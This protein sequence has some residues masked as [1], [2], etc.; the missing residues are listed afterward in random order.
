[1]LAACAFCLAPSL[2]AQADK[3]TQLLQNGAYQEAKPL[4]QKLVKQSPSNANYNYGYGVCCY[5]TGEADAALVYLKRSAD[6]KVIDAF[7]YLGK[8]YYDTYR[9]DEAV[10]SYEEYI[11]WL[12]KKKRDTSRAEE[13]LQRA[14]LAARMLK[15]VEQVTVVD[16]FVVDKED[17]L[18]AYKLSREA[19]T[20]TKSEAVTAGVDYVNERESK[21]IATV[22]LDNGRKGLTS[23]I[24][25]LNTWSEPE[26]ISSLS[27]DGNVNYPFLL[28]DGVTLYYAADGE[29]SM[30]G[31]DLFM[32]RYDSESNAYLRPDHVG[33]P[34]NSPANDYMMAIDES[35]QLGW[36]VSDRYQPEGKA[37]VYVFVPND[38]KEVYD[39]D[40][41]DEARLIAA[42]SLRSIRTTW[43]D[44]SVVD[45]AR[46]R[47]AEAQ[48]AS[49]ELATKKKR[50]FTFVVSDTKVCHTL[51][52]FTRE[53]ARRAYRQYAQKEQDLKQ[54]RQSLDA[55]RKQY[56]A[57]QKAVGA[58]I[59]DLE[60]R[61]EDM[62]A[63]LET[64]AGEVRAKELK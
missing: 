63:E 45:A 21:R 20:L 24:R 62:T 34:F 9:F 27:E 58:S 47:L 61:A 32:S 52:D 64:L 14:R 31:Y 5:E 23:S 29:G 19:G 25:L 1:M 3:A 11:D 17:F 8:A 22:G 43:T 33:M 37:C 6:R 49:T 56:E 60:Q 38:T 41:T 59:L 28:S 55:K 36:F 13:E 10:D 51:D 57:G 12:E 53:E 48:Q 18:D 50:D 16:S 35:R 30:G 46:Q 15:G 44:R 2:W 39:Y 42:A 26:V 54:I 4:Y 40:D 7:H